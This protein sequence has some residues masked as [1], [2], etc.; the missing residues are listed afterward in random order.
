MAD[1]PE[2]VASQL[3]QFVIAA[4]KKVPPASFQNQVGVRPKIPTVKDVYADCLR[5]LTDQEREVF[6]GTLARMRTAL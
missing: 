6:A 2:A 3:D 1:T 4:T 5:Q